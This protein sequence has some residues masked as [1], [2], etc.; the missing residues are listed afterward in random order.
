MSNFAGDVTPGRVKYVGGTLITKVEQPL[1]R[2]IGAAEESL[3]S[4]K[5]IDVN[6]KS[7]A[8]KGRLTAI[9]ADDK[10]ITVTVDKEGSNLTKVQIRVG[11]LGEERVA[12]AVWE[13]ME[14]RL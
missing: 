10:E 14:N 11:V 13:E 8:L 6:A 5:F 3:K 12:N 1:E 7:D 4:L 2:V 9:D